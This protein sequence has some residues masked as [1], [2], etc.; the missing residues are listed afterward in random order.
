MVASSDKGISII[1][2]SYNSKPF[3]QKCL[4]SLKK[5]SVLNN[6]ILIHVDGSTD[7]TK[8][9]LESE[10]IPFSYSENLGLSHAENTAGFRAT[11]DYVFW[12]NDDVVATP[13]WDEKLMR[14]A[15]P[16]LYV[17]ANFVEPGFGSFITRDFG[18]HTEEFQEKQFLNF[19]QDGYYNSQLFDIGFC[20]GS[21]LLSRQKFFEVG[22]FS[23]VFDKFSHN[24]IDFFYR[25][26][27][28]FPELVFMKA[29][30]VFFYHFQHGSSR[31]AQDNTSNRPELF[32][33]VH[34]ITIQEAY[35][36][37]KK[38]SFERTL[39]FGLPPSEALTSWASF[40][41]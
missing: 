26:Y 32:K 12:I 28:Q 40:P 38:G 6:E 19:I 30:D 35:D 41:E 33:S 27:K 22:G 29:N 14:H 37:I 1:L 11:K 13:G 10:N 20:F 24:D 39:K 15:H 31:N 9:W 16:N 3:L 25:L 4:E 5:Y 8:E 18:K 34:G 7:G 21:G 36:E 17:T 23:T 2:T